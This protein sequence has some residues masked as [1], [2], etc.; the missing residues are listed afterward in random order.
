MRTFTENGLQICS[1]VRMF[2]MPYDASVHHSS[3]RSNIGLMPATIQCMGA[4]LQRNL[5]VQLR[6]D[7][8]QT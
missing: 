1:D 6:P 7:N 8:Q 2:V 4:M 3:Y 5:I